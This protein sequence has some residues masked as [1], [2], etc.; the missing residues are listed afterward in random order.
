ME[1]FSFTLRQ[2]NL[3]TPQSTVHFAF[4]FVFEESSVGEITWFSWRHRVQKSSTQ[5]CKGP[6]NETRSRRKFQKSS[7]WKSV[8]WRKAPFS[9]RIT[10][11]VRPTVEI[12][13]RFQISRS[14]K[15][16]RGLGC[17]DDARSKPRFPSAVPFMSSCESQA[18]NEKISET[19]R[20]G[21]SIAVVND[22]THHVTLFWIYFFNSNRKISA[23]DLSCRI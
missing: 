12:K 22:E 5:W 4:A 19:S 23:L 8:R 17:T 14:E 20:S 21:N 6:Q 3:T 1:C 13:L 9:W 2:R 15:C 18:R 10:V 7:G 16:E 11:D